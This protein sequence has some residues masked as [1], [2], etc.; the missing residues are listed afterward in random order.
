MTNMTLQPN[1][2]ARFKTEFFIG[3][4]RRSR[5]I[6]STSSFVREWFLGAVAG[7]RSSKMVGREETSTGWE[8]KFVVT[9]EENRFLARVARRRGSDLGRNLKGV[10]KTEGAEEG[11]LK[12]RV[13]DPVWDDAGGLE[14]KEG[15]G[16]MLREA[17]W[18]ARVDFWRVCCWLLGRGRSRDVEGVVVLRR[19][20]Q[21]AAGRERVASILTEG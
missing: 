15:W 19:Q 7:D 10:W 11:G 3:S 14:R 17:L 12:I 2:L 9:E 20:Q 21:R 13:V 5:R 8:A 6:S 1:C 16:G 18:R 4:A